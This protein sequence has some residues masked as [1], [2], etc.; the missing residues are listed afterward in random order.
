ML[1]LFFFG[2]DMEEVV[3]N[4][5]YVTIFMIIFDV[6]TGLLVAGKERKINSSIN[7]DGLFKKLGIIVALAFLTMLDAYF[8]VDG[9]IIKAGVG[10]IILYEGISIIENFSKLGINLDFLTKYFEREKVEEKK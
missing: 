3:G 2:V 9:L 5:F 1:E 7:L 10:A 6:L 8:N 4:Y